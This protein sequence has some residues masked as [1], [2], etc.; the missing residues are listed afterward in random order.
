MLHTDLRPEPRA[1]LNDLYRKAH[2]KSGTVIVNDLTPEGR[3]HFNVLVDFELV[4]REDE[5]KV[6][7]CMAAAREVLSATNPVGISTLTATAKGSKPS[8]SPGRY[9]LRPTLTDN[10]DECQIN[11]QDWF[12]NDSD[13]D[14]D[15]QEGR[16]Q[17]LTPAQEIR[18]LPVEKWNANHLTAYF[19]REVW[20]EAEAKGMK[21]GPAPFNAGALSGHFAR[22]RREDGLTAEETKQIIDLFIASLQQYARKGTPI[23]KTFLARRQKLYITARR[24]VNEAKAQTYSDDE[25]LGY[26]DT[27]NDDLDDPNYWIGD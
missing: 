13:E 25:W 16:P 9:G 19:M 18:F 27:K 6:I 11:L 21:L 14:E 22:W 20:T 7:V 10:S 24:I 2:K 17:K 15:R 5:T 26:G 8:S 3:K 12:V 4:R 23:W 1:L